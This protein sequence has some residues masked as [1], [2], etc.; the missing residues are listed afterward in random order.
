[1]FITFWYLQS[2]QE[3]KRQFCIGHNVKNW[4]KNTVKQAYLPLFSPPSR[5]SRTAEVT[6]RQPGVV[7]S[8][9]PV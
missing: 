2:K 9:V 7:F 1:M 3:G 4:V 5:L 6:Q 8:F